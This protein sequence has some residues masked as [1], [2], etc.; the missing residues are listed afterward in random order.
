MTSAVHYSTP[1]PLQTEQNGG[2]GVTSRDVALI[3]LA[4][5]VLRLF[6]ALL[7][8]HVTHEAPWAHA[9]LWFYA[10]WGDG[11]SYLAQA[12]A[13]CG[14]ASKLTDFDRR[15]FPGFPALIALVHT[16]TRVH[17]EY[18]ALAIP[19]ISSGIAAG[20]AAV[21]FNDRRVGWAMAFLIPH[22]LSYSSMPMSEAP[23]L[24]FMLCGMVLARRPGVAPS[25]IGGLLLGV[26]GMIRPVA[27]FG[28]IGFFCYDL[29]RRRH[30]EAWTFAIA[31][32]I[33]VG[34]GIGLMHWWTGGD[35]LHGVHVYANDKAA[36]DGQLFTWPFHSLL[37]T[38][39]RPDL[40]D[41]RKGKIAYIWIHVVLVLTACAILVRR[42]AQ[43]R[44]ATLD[45]LCVPWLLANTL[46]VLCVGSKWGFF[47]FPRFTVP[48]M[49]AAFWAYRSIL[50]R[51]W[52]V[53][54]AV[55]L[56]SMAIA[57]DSVKRMN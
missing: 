9:P 56:V 47:A 3:A 4:A 31:S 33:T 44:A 7:S 40:P 26:A 39:H 25:L 49:P 54:V 53:W 6:I 8:P 42:V 48:A 18:I 37:A 52:W 15:V 13:M 14:D 12:R 46:F 43:K 51:R 57:I 45:V 29:Y 27:A 17:F 21:L 2:E 50:P 20:A 19:W 55:L 28:V 34:T 1:L 32:G 11:P 36:Y 16:I 10:Y 5:I 35:A 41:L 22:Y 30:V 23:L 38:P 24:A